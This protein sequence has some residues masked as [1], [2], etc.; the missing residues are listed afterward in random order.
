MFQKNDRV[1]LNDPRSTHHGRPGTIIA[2]NLDPVCNIRPRHY[3][4]LVQLDSGGFPS[5][6]PA[7]G[8]STEPIPTPMSA[9]PAVRTSHRASQPAP[10][11]SPYDFDGGFGIGGINRRQPTAAEEL[12]TIEAQIRHMERE[13]KRVRKGPLPHGQL[14]EPCPICGREPVCVDCGLCERH[15][16]C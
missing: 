6:R 11:E 1:Y 8:L 12:A 4:Y 9:Q 3:P 14:W 10:Q 7:S 15:C 13:E 16:D 5:W 2:V